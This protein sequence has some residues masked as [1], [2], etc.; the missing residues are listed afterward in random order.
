MFYLT[1]FLLS[2][3]TYILH[4]Y[5]SNCT[6]LTTL[7]FFIFFLTLSSWPSAAVASERSSESV[8]VAYVRCVHTLGIIGDSHLMHMLLRDRPCPDVL[9]VIKGG[10]LE[11]IAL[12]D[13]LHSDTGTGHTP[14]P[15]WTNPLWLDARLRDSDSSGQHPRVY[16]IITRRIWAPARGISTAMTISLSKP[17]LLTGKIQGFGVY[18]VGVRELRGTRPCTYTS[19][20]V[21]R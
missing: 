14:G 3:T 1:T 18:G 2:V 6:S 20:H 9:F 16:G 12:V 4:I 11:V 15:L 19:P 21:S 13:A 5:S 8:V 17:Q 7:P 10:P